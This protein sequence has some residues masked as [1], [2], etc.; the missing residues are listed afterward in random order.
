MTHAPH[1]EDARFKTLL[2]RWAEGDVTAAEERELLQLAQNDAF[3]KEALDGLM[4]LPEADH[5]TRLS[6]VRKRMHTAAAPGAAR[7]RIFTWSA[8]AAVL[9]LCSI[10]WLRPPTAEKNA[11][12]NAPIAAVEDEKKLDELPEQINRVPET[13]TPSKPSTSK[14]LPPAVQTVPGGRDDVAAK[15]DALKEPQMV[16]ESRDE[17]MADALPPLRSAPVIPAPANA[18]PAP[19]PVT[20]EKLK[21]P[22]IWWLDFQRYL[23]TNARLTPLARNNNVSGAV[24]LRGRLKPN[25]QLTDIEFSETLGFGLEVEALRLMQDYN[26][27]LNKDSVLEVEIKF[28]R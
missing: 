25:G 16:S 27:P 28:V 20:K 12:N 23:R 8:A 18:K 4:Q 1:T 21:T 22:D 26:W 7:W 9:I 11:S 3:R 24:R 17:P 5:A 2:E 13:T 6:N 14:P 10:W 19:A 15:K